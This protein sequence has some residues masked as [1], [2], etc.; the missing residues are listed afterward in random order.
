MDSAELFI[1]SNHDLYVD[2]QNAIKEAGFSTR[3]QH[4]YIHWIARFLSFHQHKSVSELSESDVLRFL[5]YVA[6]QLRA[7]PAKCKQA[8][9]ALAFMYQNVL[10]RPLPALAATGGAC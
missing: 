10:K 6:T 3:T 5:K 7:S 8:L 4:N 2:L 9:Q 1:Q